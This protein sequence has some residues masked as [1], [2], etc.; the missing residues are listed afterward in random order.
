MFNKTSTPWTFSEIAFA[1]RLQIQHKGV[2]IQTN[3]VPPA[4]GIDH[5]QRQPALKEQ[6][7]VEKEHRCTIRGRTCI[8][9]RAMQRIHARI[10]QRPAWTLLK[11]NA[12]SSWLFRTMRL[13]CVLSFFQKPFLILKKHG[14][15][16]LPP[17]KRNSVAFFNRGSLK[18]G[19]SKIGAPGKSFKTKK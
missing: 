10:N 13:H 17:I 19:G 12:H 4:R 2:G 1:E 6:T 15:A 7:V 3:Q 14:R 18:S 16:P 8:R 5:W 9:I 11:A